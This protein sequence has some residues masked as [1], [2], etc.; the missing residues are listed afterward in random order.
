MAIMEQL[1]LHEL[2][3]VLLIYKIDWSITE[4][5]ASCTVTVHVILPAIPVGHTTE[6]NWEII[7]IVFVV[8]DVFPISKRWNL[9][10]KSNLTSVPLIDPV[11]WRCFECRNVRSLISQ[12]TSLFITVSE[13]CRS[14]TSCKKQPTNFIFSYFY[15]THVPK[16]NK[17][18][19]E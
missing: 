1:R 6:V 12:W 19:Y 15:P 7:N 16:Y 17:L 3:E 2:E 4:G 14:S 13:D 10:I 5:I 11:Y 9:C 18:K 8:P